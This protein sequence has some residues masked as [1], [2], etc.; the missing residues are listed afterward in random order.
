MIRR[1]PR[2]TLFPYT[3]LFRSPARG[4]RL[5]VRSGRARGQDHEKDEAR[6]PQLAAESHRR[7]PCE[8]KDRK[9]TPL[10]SNDLGRSDSGVF[11]IEILARLAFCACLRARL[12]AN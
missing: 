1:P 7:D 10:N 8:E 2:S 3:T 6:D 5:R 11:L 12:S 4:A 9:S